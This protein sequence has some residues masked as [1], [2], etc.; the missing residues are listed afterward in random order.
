VTTDDDEGMGEDGRRWTRREEEVVT[1]LN[2]RP[3]PAVCL[4][5]ACSSV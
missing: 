4:P 3:R 5:A 1:E 2:T